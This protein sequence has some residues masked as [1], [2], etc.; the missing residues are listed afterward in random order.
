M[1]S[2]KTSNRRAILF[3]HSGNDMYGADL[4]LLNLL[5]GLDRSRF[6]PIVVL[7][8]DSK[9]INRLAPE[10]EKAAIEY[11]FIRMSVLRR[12]Y[13]TVLKIVP[14]F[15][16]FIVGTLS[17]AIL[18]K[19]R[20]IVL[21]HSNTLAVPC[22]AI[23]AAIARKRH[24]WHVHEI[25]M[26]PVWVRKVSH[27]LACRFSDVVV[28]VSGPVREHILRDCPGSTE[29]VKV[30]HNGIDPSPFLSGNN[31]ACIRKEFGVP[32]DSILVGMVGRVSRWKGQLV[33]L[34]AA[35]QALQENKLLFFLAVG[36]VFDDEIEYMERLR[37]SV[38][39]SGIESRFIISD[40]R[41]DICD[42][43][44][45]FDIFVLPSVLPDPFPT[46][47]LEAMAAAK[48]VIAT[49]YGGSIEMV[50]EETTGYL[51]SPKDPSALAR[52]IV[53][54]AS[55]KARAISM[56][57]AGRKRLLEEFHQG[58]FISEFELVYSGLLNQAEMRAPIV[59]HVY[60]KF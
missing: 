51:I 18:M 38:R 24:L 56:G 30:L 2:E 12:K 49:A 45:A 13:F 39:E 57:T 28:A 4:I 58:R 46:V 16:D 54:L 9:H 53:F 37:H 48:P 14:W 15:L 50:K 60:D 26:D 42:V 44:Q 47:I 7:P 22:G 33:L 1:V 20:R 10:L 17:L 11:Q 3:V 5:K 32:V 52:A 41:S 6:Y 21:V 31:M 25:I 19:K 59:E 35:Q 23:A 8:Q 55:D 34:A 29:K 27:W 36:G 43:M 40:Y